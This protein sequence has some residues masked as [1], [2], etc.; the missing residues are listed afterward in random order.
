MELLMLRDAPSAPAPPR[1]A[2]ASPD[3]LAVAWD[4]PGPG[5]T[6]PGGLIDKVMYGDVR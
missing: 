2:R 4:L 3:A 5:G 6:D 1:L